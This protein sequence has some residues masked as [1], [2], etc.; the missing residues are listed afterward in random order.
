MYRLI[1]YAKN[2]VQRFPIAASD[3]VV[4]SQPE[5]DI[6]LPFTG[7]SKRHARIRRQGD[8]LM[9]EDLGTRRGILVNG[10]RVRQARLEALD[11]VRLGGITLLVEDVSPAPMSRDDGA[12][13]QGVTLPEPTITPEVMTEHLAAIC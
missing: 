10:R 7:V 2:G 12:T 3:L 13:A 5:C 9:I 8:D 4:G 1:A 6:Y 11:E